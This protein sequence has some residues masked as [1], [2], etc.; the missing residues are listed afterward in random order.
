MMRLS[1]TDERNRG[2]G[3]CWNASVECAYGL[4]AM[5]AGSGFETME[6]A[7]RAVVWWTEDLVRGV[8]P[9]L[10]MLKLAMV[11]EEEER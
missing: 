4:Q 8:S 2:I 3:W 11:V 1:V 10:T 9:D 5:S 7:Q 6:E